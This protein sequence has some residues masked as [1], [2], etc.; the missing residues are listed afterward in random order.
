MRRLRTS[1]TRS[2][3]SG[4]GGTAVE[5]LQAENER[6]RQ[7]LHAAHASNERLRQRMAAYEDELNEERRKM[8]L[9]KEIYEL[10]RADMK[11]EREKAEREG[12]GVSHDRNDLLTATDVLAPRRKLTTEAIQPTVAQQ[13]RFGTR[14][15]SGSRFSGT[16]ISERSAK[17]PR[18]RGSILGLLGSSASSLRRG[19]ISGSRNA[20][21]AAARAKTA[22]RLRRHGSGLIRAA[23]MLGRQPPGRSERSESMP[24]ADLT[25]VRDLSVAPSTPEGRAA[26]GGNQHGRGSVVSRASSDWS[27]RDSERNSELEGSPS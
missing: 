8:A 27:C 23:S 6:L 15:R 11:R 25:D 13:A 20:P 17:T 14:E 2:F 4:G 3:S 5:A 12:W 22:P 9:E 18:R 26:A 24:T 16:T 1:L 21:A 7:E 19:S 10:D